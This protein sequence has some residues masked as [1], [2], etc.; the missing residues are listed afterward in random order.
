MIGSSNIPWSYTF[1]KDSVLAYQ[2]SYIITQQTGASKSH[3]K[4]RKYIHKLITR[5]HQLNG[6]QCE[7]CLITGC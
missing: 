4:G 7:Q 3:I 6:T 1:L 2:Y 5:F